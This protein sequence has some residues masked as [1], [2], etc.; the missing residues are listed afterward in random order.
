MVNGELLTRRELRER[1]RSVIAQQAGRAVTLEDIATDPALHD[2]RTA[3]APRILSDAIDEILVRQEARDRGFAA[4]D[5][6]V[7]R[8]L[9]TMRADND[10]DSDAE[11]QE[12]L[13]SQG[14]SA[15]ALRETLRTQIL[16]EQVRQDTFRRA[17]VTD[18]EVLS[19]YLA[20]S[21]QFHSGPSVEFREIV[22][23]LP[24]LDAT[25]G[26]VEAS[27]AYDRGLIKLVKAQDRLAAGADFADVARELSEGPSQADGGWVGPVDPKALPRPVAEALAKLPA[28]RVS[29]PVRSEDGYRLLKLE[30]RSPAIPATFAAAQG[31]VRAEMIERR[32][33]AAFMALLDRLRG[34]AILDWK[35]TAARYA[36]ENAREALRSKAP[37][38]PR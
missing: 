10:I 22:V 38:P 16:V 2:T 4:D 32:R 33:Q 9:R 30:R 29:T 20:N 27:G 8:V 7:D 26:S 1:E 11:F 15:D 13:R 36:Y 24:P 6:D 19:Y 28:G 35:D 34:Q 14:I 17:S 21:A 12:L 23:K 31:R 3:L 5:T 37:Y 25:A 18:G